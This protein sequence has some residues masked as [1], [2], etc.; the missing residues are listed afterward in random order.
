MTQA[1][2]I[3]YVLCASEMKYVIGLYRH[4][5]VAL[6]H[7]PSLHVFVVSATGSRIEALKCGL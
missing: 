3:A 5:Q 2:S 6:I 1:P 7:A 4:V